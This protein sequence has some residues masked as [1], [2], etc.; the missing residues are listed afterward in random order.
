MGNRAE[1]VIFQHFLL[2]GFLTQGYLAAFDRDGGR[3]GG[4]F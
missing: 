1:T 4:G 3:R 2:S